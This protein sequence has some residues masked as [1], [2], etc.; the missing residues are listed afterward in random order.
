MK[1]LLVALFCMVVPVAYA[2]EALTPAQIDQIQ[3]L[4]KATLANDGLA[5]LS[6]GV[7]R[8]AE[9]RS[10]AFGSADLEND[11]PVAAGSL[12]RTASISKWMTATAA[13]RLVEVGK[14]DLDAPVQRYCTQYPEKQ[15]QVTTRHLL[16][17]L[18]G[19]RHY[20][21]ANGEPR[22]TDEQR[23]AL[24]E[25]VRIEQA[26]QYTRYTDVTAPLDAFKD[27]ALIAEPGTRFQYTSP[28]YRLLGC[29]LEGAAKAPYRSLMRELVFKPAGM[30]TITEDDARTLVKG[31]VRGY[32]KENG[33]LVHA[34]FRDV[35]ENLPAGGHLASAEDLVRFASAFNSDKLVR[36]STRDLMIARPKLKDGSSVPF[37]PPTLGLGAESYYGMG[38]F[39]GSL[40]GEQLL[41]HSGSQAGTTT[42]L[43][44]APKSDV[45]VAVMTNVNGWRGAHALTTKVLEIVRAPRARE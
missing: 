28:G 14:L 18:G 36:L 21:G 34:Q 40:N 5:G 4:G 39:V 31:R 16:S 20:H 10:F 25:L 26:R 13:L 32:A 11:V 44:L 33:V 3:Q 7:A 30:A 29:V 22:D 23:R 45:A 24:D 35:S 17:H 8:G 27:D 6:I 12:F 42:E 38:I 15:W 9:V 43:L 2:G 1:L 41:M 37:A 19:V